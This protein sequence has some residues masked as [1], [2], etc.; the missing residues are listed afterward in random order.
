MKYIK[1]NNTVEKIILYKPR[2][3]LCTRRGKSRLAEEPQRLREH[4]EVPEEQQ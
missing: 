4:Y 2:L 3:Y 1:N